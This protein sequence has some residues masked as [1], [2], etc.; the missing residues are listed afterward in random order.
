MSEQLTEI[1]KGRDILGNWSEYAFI[2]TENTKKHMLINRSAFVRFTIASEKKAATIKST[3]SFADIVSEL[4]QVFFHL[5]FSFFNHSSIRSFVLDSNV[6]SSVVYL[7][8]ILQ[9]TLKKLV[10]TMDSQKLCSS[11]GKE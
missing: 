2:V 10:L 6:A 5:I 4:V 1:G 8:S 11:T 3:E 7:K 9:L